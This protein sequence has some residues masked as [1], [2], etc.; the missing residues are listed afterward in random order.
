M[1][2]NFL[3]VDY[4]LVTLEASMM[5]TLSDPLAFIENMPHFFQMTTGSGQTVHIH[6][7]PGASPFLRNPAMAG[8]QRIRGHLIITF[9]QFV[10]FFLLQFICDLKFI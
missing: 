4:V 6:W 8:S 9:L 3:I 10:C 2:H 7:S 5:P 1:P